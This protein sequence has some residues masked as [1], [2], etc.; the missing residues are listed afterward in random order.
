L[1][2]S[3]YLE[4]AAADPFYNNPSFNPNTDTSHRFELPETG[5][6]PTPTDLIM[7]YVPEPAG[8]QS[9][10]EPYT[11]NY[12]S[13][14]SSGQ[15]AKDTHTTTYSVDSTGNV[16]FF[17]TLNVDLLTTASF[18]TANQWSNTISSGTTQTA[19][20]TIYPPLSTDNYTGPTGMQVWK[21][22]VYGTFMFYPEN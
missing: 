9:T 16:N 1:T 8:G 2:S 11:S 19:N 6:P 7:N 21:D 17:V 12:S 3:D 5:S 22:N 4:I 15:T 10:G 18:T 14:T 13:T 20:F